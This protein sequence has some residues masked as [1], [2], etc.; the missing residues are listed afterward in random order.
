MFP[1]IKAGIELILDDILA[2][3]ERKEK[4]KMFSKFVANKTGELRSNADSE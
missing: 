3:K 1:Y 4:E 2:E